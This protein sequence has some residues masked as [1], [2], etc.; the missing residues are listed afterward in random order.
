MEPSQGFGG[1][2][3]HRHQQKAAYFVVLD[4]ETTGLDPGIDSIVELGA[5]LLTSPG[6]VEV[7]SFS[8]RA[9]PESEIREDAQ[10]VHGLT[11]GELENASPLTRVVKE[12]DAWV[13]REVLLCGHNVAFDAACLEHAYG[14]ANLEYRFDYHILDIWSVAYVVTHV[15]GLGVGG[16]TLDDLSAL[17]GVQRPWPH[18]ALADARASS[19]VLRAIWGAIKSGAPRS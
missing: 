18:S 9:R 10:L 17:F 5:C 3:I 12:F 15:L 19:A 16:H 14:M 1:G 7:S 11:L 6:L 8:S 4:V 2:M 13:P